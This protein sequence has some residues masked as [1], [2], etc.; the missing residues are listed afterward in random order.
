MTQ[1]LAPND[2][3]YDGGL[4]SVGEPRSTPTFTLVEL[5]VVILVTALLT[6]M[7]LA[8]LG[9]AQEKGRRTQCMHNERQIG[10]ALAQ[11]AN[12]FD[13]MIPS[14]RGGPYEG[15]STNLLR[16]RDTAYRDP[17]YLGKAVSYASVD[18]F[19][20]PAHRDWCQPGT[21]RDAWQDEGRPCASAYLYRE[22]DNG[23]DG[24]LDRNEKTPAVLMDCNIAASLSAAS[25][26]AYS[27][28]WTWVNIL[29]YDGHVRGAAN[30]PKVGE[31]FTFDLTYSN[32]DVILDVIWDNADATY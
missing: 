26:V 20:C 19:G 8:A 5:L 1:Q 24:R 16:G 13:G 7:M 9:A 21:V 28:R 18:A 30:S 10:T 23:F 22:T 32:Y 15:D 3:V 17:V 27:H 25:S 31:R 11:Y 6:A 4:S 2:E 29:C 14:R 12:D